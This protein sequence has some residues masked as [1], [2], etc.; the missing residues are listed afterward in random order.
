MPLRRVLETWSRSSGAASRLADR[1]EDPAGRGDDAARDVGVLCGAASGRRSQLVFNWRRRMLEG[2]LQAAQADEDVV[3]KKQCSDGLERPVA[4]LERLLGRK[5]MEVEFF[6]EPLERR[7]AG[8]VPITS[9]SPVV[10]VRSCVCCF[11]RC[12]RSRG[13]GLAGHLPPASPARWYAT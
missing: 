10:M 4:E 7:R 5:T 13:Y 1:R 3:G 9:S 8:G 6:E 11:Y 12:L 2:G